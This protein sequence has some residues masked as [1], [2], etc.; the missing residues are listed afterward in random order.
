MKGDP[1]FKKIIYSSMFLAIIP[2]IVV[3][4]FLLPIG[5]KYTLSI[6]PAGKFSGQFIYTDLNSDSISESV[7]TGKGTPYFYICAKDYNL[8]YYDQWNLT[9]SLNPSISEI[10]FGNYDHDRFKEIYIFTYKGDSLFLNVNELLDPAGTRMDRIFITKIGYLKGE[11]TS[12][13]KSIGFFDENGDGKDELFFGITTGFD[14]DPRR[15][16][17]FDLVHKNLHS[18]QFTG[19]ICMDPK[20]ADVD[21]DNKPEIFGDMSASGN[22]GIK[23]PFSDSS[24]WFMVFNDSLRFEFPPEEFHGYANGLQTNFYDNGIE[25]N[26]VVAHRVGGTD[27]TVLDSR[28]L[29]YSPRGKLLRYRLFSDLGIFRNFRLYIDNYIKS[30]KIYI[31][32]NK[33]FEL[34]D[35]LK[36][37][38]TVDI[39]FKSQIYAYQADLND[40]DVNEFLLY[41]EDE[42]KLAVY[43]SGLEK[44]IEMKFKT[45]HYLWKFSQY[46]SK[47]H[48]HSLFLNSGDK[49]YFLRLSRS[50]YYYLGY[51]AYPGIYLLFLM[52]I[53]LTKRIN[54]LQIVQKE[55]LNRRLVILQLQGIKSQLDPHFTFNTLNSIASLIYLED[56]QTAYDY[57]IKFTELLRG[58]INDA[59]KVYRNL[60]EE[61]E[62]VTTYLDLEKLR[63]GEKFTYEIIIGEGVSQREQVPKLVLQTF[64]ENAIKH[65]IMSSVQGG[66]LKIRVDKE[67]DYL[68]LIIE[69]NGIGREAAQGHST[70]TG[71]GLKLT[72]EFYD[73]LNQINK[74]PIRHFII[75]LHNEAGD[76]SGTR[77]EVWVPV[78]E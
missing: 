27:T 74:K 72:T 75:D 32:E 3:S 55:S 34:D 60:S 42:E 70:S 71:K 4:F 61:L 54:T 76:P 57:M 67:R 41:S 59:E 10:F 43:G 16:Y 11:V 19:I 40:D 7:F 18:S 24:T 44:L 13:L 15:V 29:V 28:I 51:L 64:A 22:F 69:D 66:L 36:L 5:S 35:S 53:I 6:E 45:S 1:I 48:Q 58:M 38:R 52:F 33:F 65:G 8:N 47:D 25:K 39:P 31:L 17:R 26:Y 46:L 9:D 78:E 37:V 12:T 63:F 77:V 20:M 62:F 14:E 49:G 21:G 50:K 2:A 56:R 23:V 30:N 73:I 68:K